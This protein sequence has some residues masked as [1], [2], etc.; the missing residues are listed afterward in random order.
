MRKNSA[1][2]N[3]KMLKDR[4]MWRLCLAR[5]SALRERVKQNLHYLCFV[6]LYPFCCLAFLGCFWVVLDCKKT[7]IITKKT[8]DFKTK[9]T[10]TTTA[11]IYD[12]I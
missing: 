1:T 4:I 5:K 7:A 12:K 10:K 11:K 6:F 2:K 8:H 9:Q 3:T